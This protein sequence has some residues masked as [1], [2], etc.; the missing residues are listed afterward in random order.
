MSDMRLMP[1]GDRYGSKGSPLAR[2][3]SIALLAVALVGAQGAGFEHRIAH[4]PGSDQHRAHGYALLH[5]NDS[6]HAPVHDCSAYDAATLGNGPPIARSEPS[7]ALPPQ[8]T[9]TAIVNAVADNSPHL[10]FQSRA[11]PRA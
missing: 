4:A 9:P 3:F 10:P 1:V 6:D 8:P 2:A 5:D 11:P 7:A